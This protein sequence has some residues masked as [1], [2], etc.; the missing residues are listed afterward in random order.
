MSGAPRSTGNGSEFEFPASEASSEENSEPSL[1]QDRDRDQYR[2]P[3]Y[4]YGQSAEAGAGESEY[5]D[6]LISAETEELL[7]SLEGPVLSSSEA[8][9]AYGQKYSHIQELLDIVTEPSAGAGAGANAGAAEEKE[10]R[11]QRVGTGEFRMILEEELREGAAHQDEFQAQFPVIAG[12]E[13]PDPG[14]SAPRAAQAPTQ[15]TQGQKLFVSL[16]TDPSS[17]IFHD[18]LHLYLQDMVL[19]H[20]LLQ[21][22]QAHAGGIVKCG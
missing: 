10:R 8:A 19:E 7:A 22:D 20:P 3:D 4:D 15:Q 11:L 9:E 13:N 16:L 17:R 2:D 1:S 12:Y 21:A 6:Q 18:A 5:G 14:S